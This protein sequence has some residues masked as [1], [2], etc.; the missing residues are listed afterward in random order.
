[1]YLFF[2]KTFKNVF[3]I[4][5]IIVITIIVIIIIMKCW[6]FNVQENFPVPN[7]MP[8]MQIYFDKKELP[9]QDIAS[10]QK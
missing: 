5:I 10:Q 9:M 7:S 3:T 4:V 1:M 2:I 8:P 6:S